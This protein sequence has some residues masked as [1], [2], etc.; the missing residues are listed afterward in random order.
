MNEEP[1]QN[2]EIRDMFDEVKATLERIEEQT[3]RTNGR[4]T[5]LEQ[6]Q[7]YVIGFCA[8]VS[9]LLFSIGIPVTFKLFNI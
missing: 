4:V 3:T 2:R 7:A 6:W 8:A 9:I 5:R 1:Y